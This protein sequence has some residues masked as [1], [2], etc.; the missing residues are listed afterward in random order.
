MS[1]NLTER[2]EIRLSP[3]MKKDAIR[4]HKK[5]GISIGEV[6]RTA[7]VNYIEKGKRNG[8]GR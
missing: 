1:E 7:F 5:H 3:K 8:Q 6:F 2:Q 4:L